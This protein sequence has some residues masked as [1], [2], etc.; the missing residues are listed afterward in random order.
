MARY[1]RRKRYYPKLYRNVT[2]GYAYVTI[3]GENHGNDPTQ[4]LT[5][6]H[7][8]YIAS[9]PVYIGHIKLRFGI[10]QFNHSNDTTVPL[11]P[12]LPWA[13]YYV[14][15]GRNA[16][17]Y[18]FNE[19]LGDPWSPTKDVLAT[20]VLTDKT[21]ETSVYLRRGRKLNTGD[22]IV[23]AFGVPGANPVGTPPQ[24]D[25]TSVNIPLN[26]SYKEYI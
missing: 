20:G 13:V 18:S 25:V 19:Q 16:G 7:G 12:G 2:P 21:T 5:V 6:G 9:S 10:T 26:I 22:S 24:W 14:A 8:I 1:Y 4:Y 23:F 17:E 11:N 15:S 3:N